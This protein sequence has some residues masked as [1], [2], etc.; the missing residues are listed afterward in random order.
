MRPEIASARVDGN[1]VAGL[2]SELFD[3]D[4]TVLVGVCGGCGSV[5]SIAEAVVELDEAA[6]IVRCRSCTHTLFTVLRDGD[7]VK[8]R[9]GVLGELSRASAEQQRDGDEHREAADGGE[10]HGVA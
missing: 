2:L 9:L 7:A 6:A 4:V 10:E 5:A 3:G 1:A 8:I